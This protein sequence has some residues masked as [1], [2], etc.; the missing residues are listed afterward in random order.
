MPLPHP[1]VAFW[2]NPLTTGERAI[3]YYSLVVAGI[4]MLAM[5]VRTWTSRQEV[6]SR[7]R[8]ALFASLGVTGAA[9]LSYVVLVLKFD[10]GYTQ[11][12]GDATGAGSM[13]MPNKDAIWS[14]APRYMDWSITV[15]LLTAELIAVSALVGLAAT[16]V[17]AI[18]MPAAFLMIFTG[19]LGGVVIGDGNSLAAL[20]T[21]GIISALFM[22]VLY[23]LFVYVLL[24]ARGRIS[25]ESAR[26]LK[27]A[28]ILQLVVFFAYPI[29]FGFQGYTARDGAWTVAAQVTL[30]LADIA[31]K[32]GFGSLIHKLA[33]LRTAEDVAA[34]EETHPESV[35]VSSAKKADAVL[36]PI[37]DTGRDR[38]RPGAQGSGD[39]RAA[40]VV[41]EELLVAEV[42]DVPGGRQTGKPARDR[43]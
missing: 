7:Y 36:P 14:W 41:V 38:P 30:S 6:G 15:P 11:T 37:K 19:Y 5:F 35:W 29:I 40:G 22:V 43:R 8:P 10:L 24:Q 3:I 13:W 33:K 20:W 9:F 34:G 28:V 26:A 42:T 12:G 27:L 21:W 39:P 4:A 18:A 23:V 2:T 17:R 16:R 1:A 25:A 32:V 31:A